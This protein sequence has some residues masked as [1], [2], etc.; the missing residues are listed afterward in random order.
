[1]LA[2]LLVN[3]NTKDT[4]NN[5]DEVEYNDDEHPKT[6]M[7]KESSPIDAEVIKGIQA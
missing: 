7:L 4:D 6:E 5:R 3:K 1:M 2:Q